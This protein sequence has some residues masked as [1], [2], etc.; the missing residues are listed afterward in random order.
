[1]IKKL[2]ELLMPINDYKPLINTENTLASVLI[3]LEKRNGELGIYFIK[4]SEYPD[5]KFS[6]Q[7]AFPGGKRKKQDETLLDTAVRETE[8]EIGIDVKKCGEIIGELNFVNP[9]TKSVRHYIVKPYVAVLTE[10]VKIAKNFEVED[11]FWIPVSHLKDKKNRDIRIRERD[12]EKI[13]DYVFSY[14]KYIIWGMTGRIVHQFL[15]RC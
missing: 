14:K 6:G 9:Y 4:R 13:N 3:I 11:V 8:E 12:G 7:I 2:E 5:D 15:I 10:K 1:M